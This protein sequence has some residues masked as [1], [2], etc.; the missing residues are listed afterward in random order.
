MVLL[1]HGS[2]IRARKHIVDALFFPE[3]HPCFRFTQIVP[4][5]VVILPLARPSPSPYAPTARPRGSMCDASPTPFPA[6]MV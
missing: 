1:S 6:N 3:D 5:I 4:L 2:C